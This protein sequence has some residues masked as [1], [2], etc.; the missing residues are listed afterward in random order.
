MLQDAFL[1]SIHVNVNSSFPLTPD[2]LV[3]SRPHRSQIRRGPGVGRLVSIRI[4][5]LCTGSI[6]PRSQSIVIVGQSIVGGDIRDN[7]FR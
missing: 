4:R 7:P 3:P 5:S 6:E 2:A 1:V